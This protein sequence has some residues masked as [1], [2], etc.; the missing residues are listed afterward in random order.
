MT[1]ELDTHGVPRAEYWLLLFP[2]LVWSWCVLALIGAFPWSTVPPA[3][4]GCWLGMG[5]LLIMPKGA[6]A[7]WQPFPGL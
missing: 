6:L 2:G 5:L 1:A 3:V 4:L 7:G